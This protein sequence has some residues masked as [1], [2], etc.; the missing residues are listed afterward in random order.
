MKVIT[1]LSLSLFFLPSSFAQQPFKQIDRDLAKVARRF[2]FVGFAVGVVDTKAVLFSKGYGYADAKQKKPFTERTIQP[3]GSVSKTFIGLA[4]LKAVELHYFKEETPIND[5]IPFS[6]VNPHRPNDTI[7]VRHLFTHTSGILDNESTYLK[8]YQLNKTPDRSLADF[9]QDY[10]VEGG[11]YYEISNFGTDAVGRRYQYSNVASALAAYLVEASS[12]MSF[13]QFTEQH[14]FRPLKL[15]DT[16]WFYN[17][18]KVDQYAT[19]YELSDTEYPGF[20]QL[21]NE[22]N[23][24]KLYSCITYPDGS[25]RTSLTDLEQYVQELLQGYHNH[26]SLFSRDFCSALFQP[27]FDTA[28]LPLNMDKNSVNQAVFWTYNRK[29]RFIHTGSDPCVFAVI[30]LDLENGIGRIV[31]INTGV[32][33]DDNEKLVNGVQ[34][35]SAALENLD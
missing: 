17:E 25:L 26:S 4:L 9:L 10:L 3:I 27:Q 12:G 31:V 35:I 13:D 24:L 16:H 20:D 18:K 7:R 1:F 29:N 30:S 19:L 15:Q 5:I 11:A 22:D 6:V 23:S 2:P 32:D 28:N 33:S 14:I 34:A 8:T 21:R